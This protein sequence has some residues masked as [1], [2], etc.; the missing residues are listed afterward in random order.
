M[1]FNARLGERIRA[2]RERLGLRQADLAAALGLSAAAVS[3][4]ERGKTA[5]DIGSLLPLAGLLGV[6]V[7]HLLAGEWRREG[8]I[9]ATVLVSA[10]ASFT[11][12]GDR[13]SPAEL[14]AATR[15]LH[16][17]V[18]E[19]VLST[20]GIPMKYAGDAF[21]A[22]YTGPERDQRAVAAALRASGHTGEWTVSV[23][24][25]AGSAACSERTSSCVS[26]GLSPTNRLQEARRTA[27][28][29]VTFCMMC[30][31]PKVVLH[32]A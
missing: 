16:F 32:R 8:T 7:D 31:R 14:A 24:V 9:E 30:V 21:I 3:K 29:S 27:R 15:T 10:A 17:H 12:L 4:W 2:R 22:L 25:A 1:Q 18:A 5:P 11:A 26:V 19:A 20:D 28:P 13:V 6:T 23:G